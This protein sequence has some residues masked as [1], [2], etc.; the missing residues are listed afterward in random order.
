MAVNERDHRA[1]SVLYVYVAQE[2]RHSLQH[3]IVHF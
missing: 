3:N 2:N 1:I